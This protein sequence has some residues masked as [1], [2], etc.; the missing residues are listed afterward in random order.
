MV[1]VANMPASVLTLF[2]PDAPYIYVI[3]GG[4]SARL[5]SEV[6]Q[7]DERRAIDMDFAVAGLYQCRLMP[8]PIIDAGDVGNLSA[9]LPLFANDE[10]PKKS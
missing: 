4:R 6:C 9:V 3:C 5:W 2:K 1:A 10:D 8:F 7:E